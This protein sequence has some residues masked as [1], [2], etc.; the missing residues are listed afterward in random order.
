MRRVFCKDVVCYESF[1]GK[2]GLKELLEEKSIQDD[3][4]I[5][6]RDRDYCNVDELPE[7]MFLYDASSLELMMLECDEVVEGICCTYYKGSLASKELI[8][9]AM[10]KLSPYSV[11][12]KKNEKNNMC[13]SFKEVGFGDLVE[14]EEEFNINKLFERLKISDSLAEECK[15]EA[16]YIDDKQLYDITNGHD[17]CVYLGEIL[18]SVGKKLGEGGCRNALLNGFR[19]NDFQKT[20]LYDKLKTYQSKHELKFVD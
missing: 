6:I 18:K 8:L 9:K 13:I 7:R 20:R 5:A 14:N 19:K 17:I 11:L 2:A 4:I 15:K 10:R 1:A 16:L 3:R 12:R